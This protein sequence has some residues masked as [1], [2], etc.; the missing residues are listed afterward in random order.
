[1]DKK[2]LL[3]DDEEGIRKVLGISLSDSGYTVFTAENGEEALD[4]F[5]RLEESG[6]WYVEAMAGAGNALT[7]LGRF[8]DA[9]PILA[10]ALEL[11][12]QLEDDGLVART[13]EYQGDRL[14]SM[15][16]AAA[17]AERYRQAVVAAEAAGDPYLVLAVGAGRVVSSCTSRASSCQRLTPGGRWWTANDRPRSVARGARALSWR[18]RHAP[19]TP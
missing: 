14:F 12:R 18:R 17:A 16:D 13:L 9:E 1:M 11:A 4:I 8:D 5:R 7:L 10:E 6:P 2:L 3:V 15:A 19:R